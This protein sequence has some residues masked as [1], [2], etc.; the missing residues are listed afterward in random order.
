MPVACR[1]DSSNRF[2][3]HLIK[4]LHRHLY[5]EDQCERFV[6]R[7]IQ[8]ECK[9]KRTNKLRFTGQIAQENMSMWFPEKGFISTH[10][11]YYMQQ[12][13]RAA[14]YYLSNSPSYWWATEQQL[15]TGLYVISA[16]AL[17]PTV[18]E[19]PL[20]CICLPACLPA[21]RSDEGCAVLKGRLWDEG[22]EEPGSCPNYSLPSA[23]SLT[24][25][26]RSVLAACYRAVDA[27][28]DRETG[29]HVELQETPTVSPAV[30]S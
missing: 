30:T 4:F 17:S 14:R 1:T 23:N 8:E 11:L 26:K 25:V 9:G 2:C 5:K 22:E 10:T 24:S 21:Y 18:P 6:R 28:P 16:D 3:L 7:Q 20:F 13:R 15:I 12:G 29:A 27:R 19:H